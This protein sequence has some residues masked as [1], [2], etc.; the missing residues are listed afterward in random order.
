M[1]IAESNPKKGAQIDPQQDIRDLRERCPD[2]LSK[3]SQIYSSLLFPESIELRLRENQ[4]AFRRSGVAAPDVDARRGELDEALQEDLVVA[5]ALLPEQFPSLR[6]P[7]R[8]VPRGTRRGRSCR[9]ATWRPRTARA[10]PV[11]DRMTARGSRGPRAPSR[12]GRDPSRRSRRCRVSGR[13]RRAPAGR[14]RRGRPRIALR[15]ARERRGSARDRVLRRRPRKRA[16][17]GE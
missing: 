17:G 15:R 1:R 7:R 6:E 3:K 12:G 2:F 8:S 10:G 13:P 9:G 16:L 4:K 5:L 14:R 11:A